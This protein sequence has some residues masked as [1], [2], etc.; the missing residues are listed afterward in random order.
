MS[1]RETAPYP[2]FIGEAVNANA[3]KMKKTMK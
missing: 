3:L 2:D 1:G